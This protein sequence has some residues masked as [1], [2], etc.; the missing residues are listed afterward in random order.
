VV[1]HDVGQPVEP[2]QRQG[3]EDPPLVRDGRREDHV[4]DRHPVGSD[5]DE[6]V[7]VGVDVTDL[8]RVN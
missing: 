8:A 3:G 6:V 1:R 2:P 7:G 5:Q 4:V